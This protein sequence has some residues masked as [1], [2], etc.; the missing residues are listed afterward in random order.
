MKNLNKLWIYGDSYSKGLGVTDDTYQYDYYKGK[1]NLIWSRLLAKEL[2]V[3]EVNKALNGIS[4]DMIFDIIKSV[5]SSIKP[6][7]KVVIG[8]TKIPRLGVYSPSAKLKLHYNKTPLRDTTRFTIPG[9]NFG[10]EWLQYIRN[11]MEDAEKD[12]MDTFLFV[13]EALKDR[14]AECIIWDSTLWSKFKSIAQETKEEIKDH[15]WGLEGH[16]D[17]AKYIL[18]EFK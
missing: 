10:E 15:H 14:G 5:Y 18:N 17:M 13:K 2:G 12:T 4:N 7:D 8:L 6:D 16:A 1:E 9:L 3:E 11:N